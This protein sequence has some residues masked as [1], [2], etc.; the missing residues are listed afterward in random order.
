MS[1]RTGLVNRPD[2]ELTPRSWTAPRGPLQSS[3]CTSRPAGVKRLPSVAVVSWGP[4]AWH[5][6][7]IGS[8]GSAAASMT[9]IEGAAVIERDGPRH[10]LRLSSRLARPVLMLRRRAVREVF[11]A[12]TGT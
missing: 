7:V 3:G 2:F 10:S 9:G 6:A 5:K 8:L 12:A 11:A 1:S 4:G